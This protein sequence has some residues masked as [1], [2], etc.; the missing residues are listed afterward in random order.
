MRAVVQRVS[1]ASVTVENKI[2]SSM[3]TGLLVLLGIEEADTEEDI[4][5]LCNKIVNL[6]IFNDDNGVMN[7]S[8][9]DVNGD[10]I[11]VSQF[12][13]YASTKKGNRPSYIKAAKP[14][15]AIALYEKSVTVFENKLGKNVGT[16][17]FGADMK[18]LLLND[19]PVTIII[20]TKNRE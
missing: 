17:A 2:I 4:E 14:D 7:R 8:L 16:G 9:L 20:D 18:V 3:R 11:L 12:T 6:R 10:A 19:G 13:L 5:W 15:V 1:E